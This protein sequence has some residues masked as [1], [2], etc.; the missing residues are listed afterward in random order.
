MEEGEVPPKDTKEGAALLKDMEEGA[1]LPQHMA[2]EDPV[3]LGAEAAAAV[4][5]P[6]EEHST[7]KP[8]RDSPGSSWPA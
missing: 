6:A 8:T 2:A 5:A 3:G 4:R 7:P 1:A